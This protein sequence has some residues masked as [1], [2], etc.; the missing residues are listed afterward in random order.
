MAAPLGDCLL[1]RL[2]QKVLAYSWLKRTV[3][4]QFVNPAGVPRHDNPMLRWVV[5]RPRTSGLFFSLGR[6]RVPPLAIEYHYSMVTKS[7]EMMDIC[8]PNK[9]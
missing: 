9:T 1:R 5:A 2:S 4:I 3:F 6:F 7:I 8:C